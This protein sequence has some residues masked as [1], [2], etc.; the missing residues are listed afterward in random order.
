MPKLVYTLYT[1]RLAYSWYIRYDD[2]DDGDDAVSI[3]QADQNRGRASTYFRL[4]LL[5]RREEI[6]RAKEASLY[7]I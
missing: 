1:N 4:H 7:D 3:S 6:Q 2:G 5:R